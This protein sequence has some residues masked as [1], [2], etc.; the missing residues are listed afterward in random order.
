MRAFLQASLEEIS[1]CELQVAANGFEALRALPRR[2]Y[3][4][5]VTDIN[6]PDINGLELIRFIKASDVHRD[7][8]IVV[9]S[10]DGAARDRDRA[11]AL[12]AVEYLIKPFSA[13]ELRR[14]VERALASPP[15]A[16]AEP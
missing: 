15:P 12:G 9:V 8:P 5:I 4:V 14:V 16:P 11:L 3:D 10:T 7:T 6:M 2:R 1:G 13:E